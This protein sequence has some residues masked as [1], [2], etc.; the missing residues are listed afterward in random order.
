[1]SGNTSSPKLFA[2]SAH[3]NVDA[4]PRYEDVPL[5]DLQPHAQPSIAH[6]KTAAYHDWEPGAPHDPQQALPLALEQLKKRRKR[7]LFREI[8]ITVWQLLILSLLL[9]LLGF[10]VGVYAGLGSKQDGQRCPENAT[11]D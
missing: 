7:W 10:G 5:A 9:A 4:P 6:L 3:R 11:S 8:S 2:T 1:M